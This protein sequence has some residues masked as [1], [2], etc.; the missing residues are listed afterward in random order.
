MLFALVRDRD[1]FTVSILEPVVGASQADLS[2]PVPDTTSEVGGSGIV[3]FREEALSVDE[4]ISLVASGAVSI[5]SVL[6]ALVRDGYTDIVSIEDPS[7]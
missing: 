2:I 1:T 4:V 3:G 6:F 7:S 5:G